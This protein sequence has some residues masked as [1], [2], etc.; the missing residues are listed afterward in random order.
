MQVHPDVKFEALGLCQTR[1]S[2]VGWAVIGKLAA[3]IKTLA[4]GNRD[5]RDVTE[6][7]NT[8]VMH[9]MSSGYVTATLLSSENPPKHNYIC[10]SCHPGT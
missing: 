3:K 8:D 4:V 7:S 5:V 6:I 2:S 9:V 10:T 1:L